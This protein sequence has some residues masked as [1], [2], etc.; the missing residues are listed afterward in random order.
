MSGEDEFA[1][2]ELAEALR[3]VSGATSV[4]IERVERG[5]VV[6]SVTADNDWDDDLS[7]GWDKP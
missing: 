3:K 5:T 4:T 2:H 6:S 1:D 7:T